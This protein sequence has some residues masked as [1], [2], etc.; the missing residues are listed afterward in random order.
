MEEITAEN[1]K[2]TK[3]ERSLTGGADV[4]EIKS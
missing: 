2:S 3:M 4:S 1:A